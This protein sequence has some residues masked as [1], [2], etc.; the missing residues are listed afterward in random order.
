M[1]RAYIKNI[2]SYFPEKIEENKIDRLT[3]RTGIHRRHIASDSENASDLAI[4][5]AEKLFEKGVDKSKVDFILLCTQ[6][7]DYF[8]PT[9]ACIL[10][11]KLG[12]KKEIGALD[13]NMGC[14]GYIY[15]LSLAKGLIETGQA[16]NILLLT[17][18]TYSKYIHPMDKTVRPLFGDAATAT[19]IVAKEAED[20]GIRGFV[21]GT[22]GSGYDKLIVPVGAMKYPYSTTTIKETTDDYGNTRSNANLYMNGAAISDFA[23]EVVPKTVECILEKCQMNKSDIDYYVFHQA[24]KFMLSFLQQK[25]ELTEYPYWNDVQ[26]YGNTVSNSIPIALV[27]VI[28]ANNIS[29][30]LKNVMV[31]GFGVGLS[32]AGC[33]ID[34]Q[35]VDK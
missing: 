32:W 15:G 14:S 4:K 7:P 25:C 30:N 24:N 26:E 23:L 9:T 19:L 11:D 3:K 34:L 17:A 27:D 16:K 13:F 12:L 20:E 31:V 2:V 6:S 1:Q 29:A 21:F 22:D 35:Y 5:V 28:K 10:Q 8:L 33:M 18:E